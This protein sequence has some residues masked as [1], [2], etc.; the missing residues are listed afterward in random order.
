MQIQQIDGPL[1]Y[2]FIR[3]QTIPINV[4]TSFPESVFLINIFHLFGRGQ[5][6]LPLDR[7]DKVLIKRLTTCI[8]ECLI[9]QALLYS[10]VKVHSKCPPSPW[11]RLRPQPVR[12]H[13]FFPLIHSHKHSFGFC[14]PKS[15]TKLNRCSTLRSL[16]C[17]FFNKWI[18]ATL[19]TRR[20]CNA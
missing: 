5:P 14:L 18:T 2:L 11:L 10:R 15:N 1:L 7:D 8:W 4:F 20:C 6:F 9:S 17:T 12:G 19:I 3:A 13:H 16:S